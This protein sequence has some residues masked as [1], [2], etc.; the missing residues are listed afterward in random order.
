MWVFQGKNERT[1][2]FFST[3]QICPER[4]RENFL[5][6]NN[7]NINPFIGLRALKDEQFS[8]SAFKYAFKVVAGYEKWVYFHTIR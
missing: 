3:T 6:N 5:N 8:S 1:L 4:E 2:I 7:N